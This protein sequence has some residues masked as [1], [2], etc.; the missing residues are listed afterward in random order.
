[1]N[2]PLGAITR[3]VRFKEK[4]KQRFDNGLAEDL[5][6]DMVWRYMKTALKKTDQGSGFNNLI[7][8]KKER[9]RDWKAVQEVFDEVFTMKELAAEIAKV[10]FSI[11]QSK[12][13]PLAEC[14]KK[15]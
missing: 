7:D 14:S 4:F 15:V 12:S 11:K 6:D 9:L 3:I 8:A 13:T 2:I 5:R 10:F 1:M